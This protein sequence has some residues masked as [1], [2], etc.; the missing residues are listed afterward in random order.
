MFKNYLKTTLRNLWRNKTYSFLNIFGLAIGIACAALIFLWVED[1]LNFDHNHQKIN[2]IYQVLENQHYDGKTYTFGATPGPLAK[3]MRNEIPGLVNTTRLTWT[4]NRLF[5]VGDKYLYEDG[6]YA[7][8]NVFSIFTLPFVE[9]NIS[10]A[11]AQPKSLVISE[12]MA[13]KFFPNELSVVG[14][15]LKVDNKDDY[16]ITGVLKDIPE[17]SSIRLSWLTPLQVY[18]DKN[19]WL[20]EWGNNGIQT[21]VELAPTTSPATI[22]KKLFGYIQTKSSDAVARPFLISMHDWRLRNHFEEGKQTGGRIQYVR[23]FSIIAWIIL[24]IA[25]INF[26]NLS[27]ARSEKGQGKWASEK[28]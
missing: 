15:T 10:K 20:L 14:K 27:T 1:E 8:S 3:G 12:K 4:L 26:M 16:L 17:N 28:F 21:Y 7:D 13:R 18:V 5:S 22:N 11:F 6:A 9:G 2:R 23:M 19:Q 25:C 24:L